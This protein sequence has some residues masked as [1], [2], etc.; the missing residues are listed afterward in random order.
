M[1]IQRIALGVFGRLDIETEPRAN[2]RPRRFR[3]GI[4]SEHPAFMAMIAKDIHQAQ[5]AELDIG[6]LEVEECLGAIDRTLRNGILRK[7]KRRRRQ[8]FYWVG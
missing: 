3:V 5:Q 1:R 7:H 6:V 2:Q 4:G 8:G